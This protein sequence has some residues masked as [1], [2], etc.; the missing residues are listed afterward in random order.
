MRQAQSGSTFFRAARRIQVRALMYLLITTN[1]AQS[2]TSG[3]RSGGKRFFL[4]VA[5]STPI[6]QRTSSVLAVALSTPM[7]QRTS[8]V[9]AVALSTPNATED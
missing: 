4:A 7:P 8:S 5:L 2:T 1:P 3:A 6:P 9:L